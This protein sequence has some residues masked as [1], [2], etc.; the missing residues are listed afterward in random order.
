MLIEL[1]ERNKLSFFPSVVNDVIRLP[2][3]M[4]KPTILNAQFRKSVCGAAKR[5]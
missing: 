1:S 3:R 4:L 5:L 2:I